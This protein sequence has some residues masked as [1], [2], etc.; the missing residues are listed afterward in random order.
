MT[1]RW[2]LIPL[3]L[4]SA[5]GAFVGPAGEKQKTALDPD[6]PYQGT[7]SDP[8]T[9][10]VD[11]SFVI[12]AP[13]H[14]KKL[15]VWLPLP[16]SDALQEVSGRDLSTFP[17]KVQ[18]TIGKEA[19]FGNQFAYFEFDHPEGAQIIRHKFTVKTWEVN[20]NVDPNKV[21]K[22]DRWPAGFDRYL[23]GERLVVVDERFRKLAGEIV[24]ERRGPALDLAAVMHWVHEN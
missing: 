23:R 24:P 20:W 16:P 9:Y 10:Q 2:C 7:R 1:L 4:S 17:L 12:T 11:L 22:V 6:L 14:T 19:V 8:V 21:L 5:L 3:L 18:P 13:Y 15:R